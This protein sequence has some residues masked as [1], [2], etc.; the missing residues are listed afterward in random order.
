MSTIPYNSK[1][2]RKKAVRGFQVIENE[3][4]WMK[5]GVVN[6][7]LC[8]NAY[9][10]NQCSF[11]KG[12]RKAMGVGREP[13][14]EILA[15]R[16]VSYLQ[17][18]FRGTSRPCR[19]VLSGRIE[20]PKICVLN[21]ECY[22]CAFDQMLDDIDLNNI[23]RTPD[24]ELAG[25]YKMARGCYY[26]PGHSWARFEHGGRVRIGSDDFM[27][28]LFGSP[29]NLH[30]PPL[31]EKIV[32]SSVGW[33]FSRGKFQAAVLSPVTGTV[34]AVNHNAR[35]HPEIVHEDPYH[36]G[37]LFMV[38]PESP[39]RNLKGLYFGS[40]SE[41]W[42]EQEGQKLLE[43]V[44]S[45]YAGLSAIGGKPVDD[46]FG[47]LPHIGWDALVKVFLQTERIPAQDA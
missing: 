4:I 31:G 37:W 2:G 18:K 42:M 21:Y 47:K 43:M 15:P 20:T 10:C 11:D 38:E 33:A 30:L 19:H 9:D 5:A 29:H 8:D 45:R 22:H 12:M 16:W 36:N 7:R 44:G 13:E 41:R 14:T 27:A 34:L 28:K 32:Q 1:E 24:C 40:E 39:K 46:V 17:K 35:E 26:H 25:G 3:C 6:F 23:G